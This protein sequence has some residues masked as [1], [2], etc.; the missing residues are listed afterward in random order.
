MHDWLV[1]TLVDYV[2]APMDRIDESV[3]AEARRRLIDSIG[4]AVAAFDASGPIA[5]REAAAATPVPDGSRVWG[6]TTRTSLEMAVLANCAAVRYLDYNDAYFGEASGTHPSDMIPGLLAV[7]ELYRSSGRALLEAIAL[8]YEVAVSS[9][10]GLGAR[11]FGWDHVNF[12]AI[13]ACC[14]AGRLMG[15]SRESLA[16]A[17]SI[18]VV[19]HAAMGQTREGDL[20]MWK[21]LAA[22][23]AVRHAVYACRLAEAGVQGPHEPFEGKEGFVKLIRGG[24]YADRDAFSAIKRGDPPVRILDTHVKAWPMGIV[25]QSGVDAALRIHARLADPNEIEDVEIATFKAAIDRNASTEKWRPTTRET[26]DHSLP[27]GVSMALLEGR[28]DAAS[29]ALERV[30]DQSMHQFMAQRVRLVEDPRL[31]SGYPEGFPTRVTVQTRSGEKLVE[32]VTHYRGH[33][34]NPLD[35][36]DLDSKFTGLVRDVL[37]TAPTSALLAE[38]RGIGDSPTVDHIGEM[39]VKEER[40]RWAL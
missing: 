10:D 35:D 1:T 21:G 16:D 13:G 23:D 28:V 9:A 37:G 27:Y 24:E 34:R 2:R 36:S 40:R 14:A 11:E 22:P 7:A 29:F 31:T 20:S 25:S 38:L 12:T 33:A 17:L 30:R 3:L 39:L 5:V 6:S 4:V 19:S 8:G 26:A 15:L 18:T 32:E